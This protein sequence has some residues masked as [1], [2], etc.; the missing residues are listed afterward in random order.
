MSKSCFKGTVYVIKDIVSI[1]VKINRIDGELVLR[2]RSSD[3]NGSGTE[4]ERALMV[5]EAPILH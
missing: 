1:E 5:E 2:R 3:V 4:N